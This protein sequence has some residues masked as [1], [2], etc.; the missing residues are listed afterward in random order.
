MKNV[1]DFYVKIAYDVAAQS[2]CAK[3]KV[4][5][6]AVRDNSII[7]FGF[8]GTC[9]GWHTNACEDMEGKTTDAVVHAEE[10]IVCK[11]AREGKSLDK[12]T[13]YITYAPCMRC[14]RLLYQAGVDKVI[15]VEDNDKGGKEMLL[16][17]G[18]N[19][20]RYI[21]GRQ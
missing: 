19:L 2:R 6:V 17:L 14:S 8:N 4:G 7:D 13:I 18:V 11:C 15:Y 12:A 16:S 3:R 9:Y 5:A 10:N 21:N 20:E 1:D